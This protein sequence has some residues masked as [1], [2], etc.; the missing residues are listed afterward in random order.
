MKCILCVALAATLF[1]F[2]LATSSIADPIPGR[3]VLKFQ[4]LPM[5]NTTIP[6]VDGPQIFHGH[7]E[8]ST[9]WGMPT[10]ASNFTSHF[11]G[12]FMAD[13][14]ADHFD[15]PVVHVKWWGSYLNRPT[16]LPPDQQQVRRFLISFENDVPETAAGGFSHPGEEKFNQIVSLDTDG[17]LTKGEGSFTEKEISPIS[18]DG[19]IY[20]YNA[21]LFLDKAFLQ[22]AETVYWLKIVA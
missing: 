12:T 22:K 2:G 10:G 13:D 20:E 8:L 21:E 3:D 17:V 7:D 6:G 1:T 16:S 5:I 18:V 19:P 11:D 9:A 14:F 4:Q 15:T